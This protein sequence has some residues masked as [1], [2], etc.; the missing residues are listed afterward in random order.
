M[1]KNEIIAALA[2]NHQHFRDDLLKL[3]TTEFTSSFPGKWTPGQ[4]FQHIIL[5]VSPVVF[6]FRLPTFVLKLLFG[7]TNRPSRSFEELVTKYKYK[8]AQGGRATGRFIPRPV[9]FAERE[10]LVRKY[11]RK[12]E[13]LHSLVAKTSEADLDNY[14]LPHPLLG[15]LTLR[16]MLY[17]TIHH[18]KHHHDL[19]N[20]GLYN[21]AK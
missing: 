9:S 16:E 13:A 20:T 3:G 17:F 10:R 14:I 7:K 2:G 12:I 18:V 11:N 21:P 1:E 6:A 5:S 4:H 19:V 8:L 15:K